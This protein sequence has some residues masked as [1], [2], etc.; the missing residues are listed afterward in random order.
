MCN[1]FL[2]Q[3]NWRTFVNGVTPLVVS[4]LSSGGDMLHKTIKIFLFSLC[5][6]VLLKAQGV[7]SARIYI[8]IANTALFK[9]EYQTAID[10]YKSA[11]RFRPEHA[12]VTYNIAC[13]YSLLDN[14]TE[15]LKWLGNAI[16]LGYYTF[17]DDEDLSN[18]KGTKQYKKLLAK[19][20]KLLA[21]LKGKVFEP[22]VLL[23]AN[24]DSSVSYPLIIGL[25]GYGSNPVDFSRLFEKIKDKLGYIVCCP[26]APIVMGKISFN[27]GE[28][29]QAEN[30]ILG[31]I[32]FVQNRHKID[33]EKVILL[34]FS[35][36]GSIVYYIG[37]KDAGL[38]KGVVSIAGNYDTTWN[39][40]LST[41]KEESLKFFVM[42]GEE[43]SEN[44]IN[45]N[46]EALKQLIKARITVS[47]NMYAGYG[48][49]VPGDAEFEIEQAIRWLEKE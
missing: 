6:L 44:R 38:F 28:L 47:I 30:R 8:Q 4:I 21:Q 33:N 41:A 46:I 31:T 48:H 2:L 7:D 5:V 27:W 9:G 12:G 36:G 37:L 34:G 22:I 15:G 35:Q 19:A 29:D 14:K 24:Y 42:L 26:Y 20:N 39:Q 16:D 43:E 25:H 10:N 17:D 11:L 1:S 3:L 49:T 13:A 40:Y 45:A 32:D 18:I 23:P